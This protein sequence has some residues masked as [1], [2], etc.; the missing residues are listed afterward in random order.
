MSTRSLTDCEGNA[1][2]PMRL[3]PFL[4]AFRGAVIQDGDADYDSAPRL[5]NASIDKRPGLF[6]RCSGLADVI[7]AVRFAREH[8][9]LVAIRGGGHNVGGRALS[10]H[11]TNRRLNA[12]RAAGP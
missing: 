1:L 3:E 8:G 5:W 2:N 7:I 11:S 9:L 4:T 6:V 10:D 12:S